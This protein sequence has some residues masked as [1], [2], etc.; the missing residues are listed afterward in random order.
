MTKSKNLAKLKNPIVRAMGF[1]IFKAK[2]AFTHLRQAFTK[3][4]ILYHFDP[5]CHIRIKTN[6]FDYAIS[7]VLS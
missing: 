6:A 3:A 5:E 7:R 2:V 4:L 1:L